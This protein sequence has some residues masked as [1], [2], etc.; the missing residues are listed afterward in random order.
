MGLGY[1]FQL[2][3]LYQKWCFRLSEVSKSMHPESRLYCI[4]FP[5]FNAHVPTFYDIQNKKYCFHIKRGSKY[6]LLLSKAKQVYRLNLMKNNKS[7]NQKAVI[8]MYIIF[9]IYQMAQLCIIYYK[10]L[11]RVKLKNEK[12]M[13]FNLVIKKIKSLS[14]KS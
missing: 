8:N 7:Y 2:M 9:I 10:K 4:V 11:P 5:V 12:D 14:H 13:Q 6:H 1:C 3:F